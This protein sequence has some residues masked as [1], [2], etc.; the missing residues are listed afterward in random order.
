M[1]IIEAYYDP[2]IKEMP[3]YAKW[4]E[5]VIKLVATFFENEEGHLV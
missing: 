4:N 2:T 5:D 3:K 1:N